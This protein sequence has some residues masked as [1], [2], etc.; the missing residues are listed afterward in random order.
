[1]YANNSV[2]IYKSGHKEYTKIV[3]CFLEKGIQKV[4]NTDFKTNYIFSS[5]NG[6]RIFFVE[7]GD[8]DTSK[9][10]ELNTSS[11]SESYICDIA[12]YGDIIG[13]ELLF[14][15]LSQS[16]YPMVDLWKLKLDGFS[17]KK[18]IIGEL[19]L[20]DLYI[21]PNGKYI[22]ANTF[23]FSKKETVIFNLE[24]KAFAVIDIDLSNSNYFAFSFGEKVGFYHP[25][26]HDFI[27]YDIPNE[28][29]LKREIDK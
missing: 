11:G 4:I 7:D 25:K 3:I 28:F 22:L 23:T 10:F 24:S 19:F 26:N 18:M 12:Y 16:G 15:Q 21:F 13:E 27:F 14:F 6:D 2:L 29:I 9:L 17:D 20:N 8:D 1:M 5:L